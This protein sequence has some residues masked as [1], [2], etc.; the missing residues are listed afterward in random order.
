[1]ALINELVEVKAAGGIFRD[2]TSATVAYNFEEQSFRHF[3]LQLAEP[4]LK[5]LRLKPG[6]RVDISMAGKALIKDGYIKVR[7]V[8]YDAH[9]HAVQIDGLGKLGP[10]GGAS[11]DLS[12]GGQFQDQTFEAI[13]NAVL[14]KG[15]FKFRMDNPPDGA[16]EKFKNAIPY[17][18]ERIWEFLERLARQRAIRLR[19]D[20]DGTLVGGSGGGGGGSTLKEGENI[21]AAQMHWEFPEAAG[22]VARGQ[23]Q[24]SNEV[25]GRP[26]AEI[27][28]KT[29]LSSG[30]KDLRYIVPIE[31][32]TT[33]KAAQLRADYEAMQIESS[34]LIVNVTHQGFLKPGGGG[35]W[36]LSDEVT[37]ISPML[38]PLND[39][40]MDLKV[41]GV[42]M[43]QS[44]SG[45]TTVVDCRNKGAFRRQ[46]GSGGDAPTFGGA[47]S[48]ASSET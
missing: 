36:E 42:T 28:A 7:Q 48:P 34:I 22:V 12:N 9:R 26:Q 30:N 40:K 35:L 3:R 31:D 43:S 2:W 23:G 11:V 6:D 21:L 14:K 45:T 17:T 1:M 32:A 27:S 8:A 19:S 44:E 29:E 24:G 4:D 38:F 41:W 15:G 20:A 25:F 10:I 13:A 46:S 47:A 37:V 5:T 39:G 16:D 33:K 18:G